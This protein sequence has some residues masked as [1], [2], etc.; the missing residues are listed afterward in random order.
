MVYWTD[1]IFGRIPSA[2][3]EDADCIALLNSI[4]EAGDILMGDLNARFGEMSDDSI[5]NDRGLALI[6]WLTWNN[7][8][9]ITPTIT[10]PT[11]VTLYTSGRKN[12]QVNCRPL[13]R[14]H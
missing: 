7:L 12:L 13:C 14:S 6:E 5:L 8:D 1:E 4:Y 3:L 2:R 9:L 11:F 10:R